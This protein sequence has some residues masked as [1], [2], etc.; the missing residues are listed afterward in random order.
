M[1]DDECS[2]VDIVTTKVVKFHSNCI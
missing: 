2:F 1:R